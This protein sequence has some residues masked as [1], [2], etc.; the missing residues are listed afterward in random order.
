MM[1]RIQS[2]GEAR[3]YFRWTE[4]TGAKAVGSEQA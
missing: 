1:R 3:V 4:I 2:W